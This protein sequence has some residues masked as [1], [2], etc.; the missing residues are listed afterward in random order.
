[1]QAREDP[2]QVKEARSKK[3]SPQKN[4]D[5]EEVEEA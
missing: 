1:M 2:E 5:E 4:D 3:S